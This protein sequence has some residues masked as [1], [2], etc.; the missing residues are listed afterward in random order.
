MPALEI[1]LNDKEIYRLM[2]GEAIHC[3]KHDDYRDIVIRKEEWKPAPLEVTSLNATKIKVR[4]N[5]TDETLKQF[6]DSISKPTPWTPNPED[7]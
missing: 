1:I 7:E 4:S 6:H 3:G 2:Q 5:I